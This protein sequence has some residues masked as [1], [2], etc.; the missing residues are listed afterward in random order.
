MLLMMIQLLNKG[1]FILLI[2]IGVIVNITAQKVGD[3]YINRDSTGISGSVIV[4]LTNDTLCFINVDVD[5]M[6][7]NYIYQWNKKELKKIVKNEKLD[8]FP[9]EEWFDYYP[10]KIEEKKVIITAYGEELIYVSEKKFL[11]LRDKKFKKL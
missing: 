1:L 2:L 8:S 7:Y 6:S 11:K 5:E 9:N 10:Y 4:F 3:I